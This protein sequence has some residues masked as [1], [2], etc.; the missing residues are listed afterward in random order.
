MKKRRLIAPILLQLVVGGLFA[1]P[2]V[3]IGI[4]GYLRGE[5]FFRGL[6]ASYWREQLL[7]RERLREERASQPFIDRVPAR[8]P[9]HWTDSLPS[10]LRKKS[11]VDDLD[12]PLFER[13]IEALTVLLDLLRDQDPEVR[14][15]ACVEIGKIGPRAAPA[16]PALIEQL[17]EEKG[18]LRHGPAEALGR[19][20]AT[21]VAPLLER[22]RR[23][24]DAEDSIF[25]ALERMGPE[26]E[27]AIPM[28]LDAL[29]DQDRHGAS[30]ALG[31]IGPRAVP[32][33]LEGLESPDC[34]VRWRATL[35]L[36]ET[37][38]DPEVLVPIFIKLLRDAD[39]NVRQ[40]AAGGLG[41]LAAFGRLGAFSDEAVAALIE[42]LNDRAR[43][44]AREAIDS[45]GWIGPKAQAAVPAL[46]RMLEEEEDNYMRDCI[47]RSLK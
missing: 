18:G 2:I 28:L 45:L 3:R 47:Q 22:L 29:K 31:R 36:Q 27:P 21:A 32:A 13:D 33:L 8:A 23:E 15:S 16:I 14:Q 39:G 41:H 44:A 11:A 34:N 46:T 25:L 43:Y 30:R 10:F 4:E 38:A 1:L 5:S 6:P 35:A 12:A 9:R 24:P 40:S 26:A 17:M 19:I 20:G 37:R 7:L 42:A